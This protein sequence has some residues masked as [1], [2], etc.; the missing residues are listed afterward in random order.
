[1]SHE[2]R[3]EGSVKEARSRWMFDKNEIENSVPSKMGREGEVPKEVNI[4]LLPFQGVVK[5]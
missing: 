1:M 2:L 3:E 5:D 4:I